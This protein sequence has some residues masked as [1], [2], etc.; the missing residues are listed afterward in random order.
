MFRR[1]VAAVFVLST[2][3]AVHRTVG[4]GIAGAGLVATGSLH[5]QSG[6]HELILAE[7]LMHDQ[8]TLR[9]KEQGSQ[10]YMENTDYHATKVS[11]LA[12]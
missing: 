1:I 7:V 6:R 4:H 5:K 2:L 3:L 12:E 8:S 9:D 10:S 11:T